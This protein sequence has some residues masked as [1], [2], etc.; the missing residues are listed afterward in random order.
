MQSAEA[1]HGARL[2]REQRAIG[3][4]A[5]VKIIKN[6]PAFDKHFTIVEH[7]CWNPFQ[8]VMSCDQI[9]IA[10]SRPGYVIIDNP[11]NLE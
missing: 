4:D 10:K 5:F 2:R 1:P 11:I 3:T 9:T 6:G 7:C 8:R